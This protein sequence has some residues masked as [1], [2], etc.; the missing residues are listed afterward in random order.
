MMLPHQPSA[1]ESITLDVMSLLAYEERKK[2][3]L[4]SL[5]INGSSSLLR[6]ISNRLTADSL[7]STRPL[8]IYLCYIHFLCIPES[9][10]L[11]FFLHILRPHRTILITPNVFFL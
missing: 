6:T 7:K 2:K 1:I 4:G 10:R 5:T 3:F 9:Q 8:S 11:S